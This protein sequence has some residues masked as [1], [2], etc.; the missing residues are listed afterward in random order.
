MYLLETLAKC[1]QKTSESVSLK[2]CCLH[3]CSSSGLT[4]DAGTSVIP[5]RI[6]AMPISLLYQHISDFLLHEP[7]LVLYGLLKYQKS[8]FHMGNDLK[9]L[10]YISP[11]FI[12]ALKYRAT[13]SWNREMPLTVSQQRE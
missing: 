6:S 8:K 9:H 7:V 1:T 4:F 3:S 13:D 12:N 5:P 10:E 2:S 11:T